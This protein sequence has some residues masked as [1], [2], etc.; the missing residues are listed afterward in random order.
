MRESEKRHDQCEELY[1]MVID[2]PDPHGVGEAPQLPGCIAQEEQDGDQNGQA[3]C[4]F[5]LH[6]AS[7]SRARHMAEARRGVDRDTPHE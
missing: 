5:K 2:H 6:A 1:D 4:E 3:E 7:L